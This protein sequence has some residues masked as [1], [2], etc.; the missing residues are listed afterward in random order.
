[1]TFVMAVEG[2]L[3]RW[4]QRAWVAL[5]DFFQRHISQFIAAA[6]LLLAMAVGALAPRATTG[7]VLLAVLGVL[8]VT[9]LAYLCVQFIVR[10]REWAPVLVLA[11]C[12]FIPLSIP[13][14]GSRYVLSLILTLL[15]FGLWLLRMLTVERRLALMPSLANAPLLGFIAVVLISLVWSNLFRDVTVGVWSS[16]PLVQISS[17]LVMI[18][19]PALYLMVGNY[20]REMKW[21]KIMTA[22]M[23]AGAVVGLFAEFVSTLI[24]VQVRGTFSMWAVTLPVALFLFNRNI[25]WYWRVGLL[26]VA[27]GWCYWSF[28]LRITWVASWLPT[29]VALTVLVLMRSRA[30]LVALVVASVIWAVVNFDFI[31]TTLSAEDAE[32]GQTRVAAWAQNWIITR[33]HWLFGTG[34]AGYAVYYMSYFPNQAMATHSNYLDIL[35]QLG[36]TGALCY[37][38]IFAAVS[39]LGLR[40]AQRL[41]GRGDFAE[42]LA[43]AALAGTIGCLVINAFGDWLIPFAYTQGISGFDYAAYNWLFMGVIPVLD[44]LTRPP[45]SDASHA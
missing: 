24:P 23:I 27:L 10:K 9:P 17:A 6:V 37:V 42:A 30:M 43:N 32:S 36:V 20:F 2:R 19:L 5:E 11:V 25:A 15:F 29:L 8:V 34:P 18:M 45:A 12:L 26:G 16:F 41:R 35:S 1:M 22:V 39:W 7:I 28:G 21:L 13:V 44:R 3:K 14:R 38:G 31:S 40:L 4:W 33:E